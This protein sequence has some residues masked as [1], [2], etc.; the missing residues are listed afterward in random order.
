MA[1]DRPR[2]AQ[3]LDGTR[4]GR[5]AARGGV[6]PLTPGPARRPRGPSRAPRAARALDAQLRARGALRRGRVAAARARRAGALGRPA[7]GRQPARERGRGPPGPRAPG[8]PPL[9]GRR[10]GARPRIDRG[11]A[12]ARGVRARHRAGQPRQLPGLRS[13]RDRVE[14]AGLGLRGHRPPVDGPAAGGRRPS[15]CGGPR[16]GGPQ[17]APVRGVAGGLPAHGPPRHLQLLRGVHPH[18]RLHVQPA[19][20]VAEG[21]PP[22]PVAAARRVAELPAVVPRVAPGPQR[23]LPSGP[24]LH[25]PRPQQ[26]ARDRARLPAAGRE[27][28]ALGGRSLPAQPRLRQRRRGRQAT[29]A[30]LPDDGRGHRALHPRGRHLGLGLTRRRRRARRGARLR[31]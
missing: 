18:H 4:G 6:L 8:L 14:P 22:D 24:G 20:Q 10:P 23:A 15:R 7:H 2:H 12:G 31:R 11:D 25:R 30:R 29:G 28:P 3:G 16:D 5:R 26:E 9:R 1:D 27:L 19:R 13:R 21:D 17:R